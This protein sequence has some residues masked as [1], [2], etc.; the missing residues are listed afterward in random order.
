MDP[1]VA[2]FGPVRLL[3]LQPTPFC[4]LDCDY[5]YLPDRGDRTRL[6]F[7]LLEA[8]LERVLESPFFDGGFTLLWHAGEPLTVPIRFYDE[9]TARIRGVLARHG[10]PP[11]TVVQSL[12]TNATVITEAWC[13][14]FARNDIHVGVS[15]D[16]PAFLHDA[17]RVTR[18]GLPTH[19]AA[20]RG[21]GWL[22]RCG[23]P[24]EVISV[25]TADGLD[26]A[27]AIAAF[28]LEHGIADVGFNMEETEGANAHSSLETGAAE[29]PALEGRYRRFMERIWQRCREYP[30]A[31]RIREFEGITSLA[32]SD[33]RLDHTDMN[34]PFVIV[35]VDARGHVS[36]FDP[37]LLSVHTERFGT[38]AFGHVQHDR[39]V[40]LAA[41]D[42][43]QQVHREIRA[44]VERCRASC[45]YFGL[46]GGGAG[47]NKYWEHGRFDATTTEHC[48]FRIQ[49]VADVVLAGM[50]RELGLAG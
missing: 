23:I 16:G 1:A 41:S 4:N 14:C 15:L 47:S 17:H 13:E 5:C 34:T 48:R 21:V 29:R 27:D 32:C 28:F 26:H 43:F 22:Q 42:K 20:M 10:L 7:E 39:L 44:G 12:Q 33:G 50:E 8:A 46:C 11:T 40:D 6:S 30:G 45:D 19:A 18:T 24:F 49:L 3:V 36:T 35:N 2:G 37:E 31:L 25:L 38:F 9:A